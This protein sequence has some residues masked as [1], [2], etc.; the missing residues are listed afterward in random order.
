MCVGVSER[1]SHLL[2]FEVTQGL[3]H[4]RAA[5]LLLRVARFQPDDGLR[6]VDQTLDL[7]LVVYDALPLFL[8]TCKKREKNPKN[9]LSLRLRLSATHRS[10]TL[11]RPQKH[12]I[13]SFC[14]PARS[15]ARHTNCTPHTQIVSSE[16]RSCFWS[17]LWFVSG[18]I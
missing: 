8:R 15:A 7:P 14:E 11:H 10:K 16:R 1:V 9:Y 17:G 12:S 18:R 6:L 5:A 2:L 3:H 13:E 4:D